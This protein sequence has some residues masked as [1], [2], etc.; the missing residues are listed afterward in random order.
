[1]IFLRVMIHKWKVEIELSCPIRQF[2]AKAFRGRFMF[3]LSFL[4]DICGNP[5][6]LGCQTRVHVCL[7]AERAR[8]LFDGIELIE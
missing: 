8:T 7:L 4:L 2:G 6:T 5:T 3:S 1:M